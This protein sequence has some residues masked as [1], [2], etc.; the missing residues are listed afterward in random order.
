MKHVAITG[1]TGFVGSAL[2]IKLAQIGY[3]VHALYRSSAKARILNHA[4]IRLFH[5]DLNDASSLENAM[6]GCEGLFHTAAYVRIWSKQPSNYHEIN[7]QGTQNVLMAAKKCGITRAVFTSTA[8]I[9][10]PSKGIPTDENQS[11]TVLLNLYEETKQ[12]ANELILEN[13]NTAFETVIVYPTRI[14]GPGVLGTSNSITGMVDQ[15]LK[16]QWHFIPSNG[17]S[18]GNYVFIDDVVNGHILAYEKGRAGGKYILS[19]ANLSYR[20]FF[21]IVKRITNTKHKLVKVPAFLL[22]VVAQLMLLRANLTGK[23]PLITKAFVTKIL[24]NW[25]VSCHK[26]AIELGYQPKPFAEAME[27]TIHWL[28]S[29]NSKTI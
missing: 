3:Q 19:G 17:K 23:P 27:D 14:F 29:L 12:R 5:G 7:I 24:N 13:N 4:N 26:A 11:N 18:L 21:E 2:A 28:A 16:G 25:E 6:E 8:G 1:S 22:Q 10:G 20:D 15:Y 9:F